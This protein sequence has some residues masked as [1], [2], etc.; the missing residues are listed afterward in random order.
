ARVERVVRLALRALG[1]D[2]EMGLVLD[3]RPAHGG[4]VLIAP[5][6]VL[7]APRLLLRLS[8]G[9]QALVAKV[10]ERAAMEVVRAALGDDV[11]HA[12]G[13]AAVVGLVYG[14]LDV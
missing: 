13:R 5:V 12:A 6:R 1:G 4:A 9:V 10:F 3:D 11:Q 14:R 8:L 2:E 7:S